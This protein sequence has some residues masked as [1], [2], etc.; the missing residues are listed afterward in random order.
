CR[1]I[2]VE[3]EVEREVVTGARGDDQEGQVMARRHLGDQRLG[4]VAAR[5]RQQVRAL[6]DRPAGQR[7][8][9]LAAVEQNHV[10]AGRAGPVGQVEAVH[11]AAAGPGV[12]Q[13]PGVAGRLDH[14]PPGPPGPPGPAGPRGQG[15]GAGRAAV[16]AGAHRARWPRADPSMPGTAYGVSTTTGATTDSTA[17][18]TRSTPV[19]ARTHHTPTAASASP[20]TPT[21]SHST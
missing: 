3:A 4:A 12:H 16:T 18:R 6:G 17:P 7:G 20:A 11:L 19:W 1:I 13:H 15:S 2:T 14:R 9:V 21:S 10:A 8:D 5:D